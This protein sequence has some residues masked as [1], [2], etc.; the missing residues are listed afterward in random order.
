MEY[1][2]LV[3]LAGTG[4]LGGTCG[5]LGI[6]LLL[7]RRALV[8]D[9][10]S[11]AALPG[12]AI[13][14]LL[15]TLVLGGERSLGALLIGG[16]VSAAVA[17]IFLL[18]VRLARHTKEDSVIAI[19]LSSFFGLGVAL[20]GIIQ[21]LPVGHAAGLQNYIYGDSASLLLSDVYLIGGIAFLVFVVGIGLFKEFNLLCFDQDFAAANG[22]RCSL[23]D[24][25][26]IFLTVVTVVISLQA[27]GLLLIIALLILPAI[28]ARFWGARV[29]TQ[30]VIAAAVG[31]VSAGAGTLLSS[32][33]DFLPTGATIVLVAGVFFVVSVFAGRRHAVLAAVVTLF[34][35]R[36]YYLLRQLLLGVRHLID[37]NELA[38]NINDHYYL[39][40]NTQ[41]TLHN[42]HNRLALQRYKIRLALRIARRRR[43]VVRTDKLTHR[44]TTRGVGVLLQ[45]IYAHEYY[46]AFIY[47]FPQLISQI[48]HTDSFNFAEWLD[49]RERR[50]LEAHLV[51]DNPYFESL[52]ARGILSP[53]GAHPTGSGAGGI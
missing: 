31:A 21:K 51:G 40:L 34:T 36:R 47:L 25:V 3:V 19:L 39:H 30:S 52:Y 43:Y 18:I 6:F 4:L 16:G 42:L 23:L 41:F 10:I 17:M 44:L 15:V 1:N 2:S 46:H 38:D 12:I 22:Y 5:L 27:V 7:R 35:Q 50:Q 33:V 13:A 14:Y 24:G 29:V 49:A 53:H 48:Q 32:L 20:L 26:L 45:T 11:H 37:M 9:A 8:G 28:T